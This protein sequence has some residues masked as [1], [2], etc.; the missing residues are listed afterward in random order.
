[1]KPD[2]QQRAM[3]AV[4]VSLLWLAVLCLA[5]PSQQAMSFS[6]FR[7]T[8]GNH[9][10]TRPRTSAWSSIPNDTLLQPKLIGTDLDAFAVWLQFGAVSCDSGSS[11]DCSLH[12]SNVLPYHLPHTHTLSL[13]H[14]FT[15]SF[16]PS[17]LHSFTPSLLHSLTHT[18]KH[19][20]LHTHTQT[21]T[22]THTHSL[23]HSHDAFAQPIEC[24]HR[25]RA[26]CPKSW[27]HQ[28]LQVCQVAAVDPTGGEKGA[29]L[30]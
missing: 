17:L 10:A 13:F 26:R 3:A 20:L 23:A 21:F 28:L 12:C 25:N 30:F 29:A 14:S 18:H 19:S 5:Q 8:D 6:H 27:H 4:L 15:H 11:I 24:C 1:M 2:Q 7:D 16:T 22:H 9:S